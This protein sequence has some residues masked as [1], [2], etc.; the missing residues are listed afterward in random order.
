M[1]TDRIQPQPHTQQQ[2]GL[3]GHS[4]DP[5]NDL[6]KPYVFY[7]AIPGGGWLALASYDTSDEAVERL[8]ASENGRDTYRITGPEG[9]VVVGPNA[10]VID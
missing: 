6:L 3:R 2:P 10:L 8:R 5:E 9:E 1:D 7:R 4:W